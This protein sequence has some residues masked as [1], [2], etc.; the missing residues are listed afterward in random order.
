MYR[1]IFNILLVQVTEKKSNQSFD[2]KTFRFS[3]S[4]MFP[5]KS[6]VLDN[7]KLYMAVQEISKA[8][9]YFWNLKFLLDS[10]KK[11]KQKNKKT[12][13]QQQK[14]TTTTTTK[15]QRDSSSSISSLILHSVILSPPSYI[16]D[17]TFN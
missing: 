2:R 6:A 17:L 4:D 7:K 1:S 11:T 13:E 10:K 3:R 5:K 14:T 9:I 8:I 15:R 12:N 16:A